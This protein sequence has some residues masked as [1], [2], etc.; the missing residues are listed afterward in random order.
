MLHFNQ[1][2]HVIQAAMAAQGIALGRF[3]LLSAAIAQ[4]RLVTLI[5][6][7][8]TPASSH[9]YW[10][11]RGIYANRPEVDRAVQWI[12]TEAAQ[13]ERMSTSFCKERA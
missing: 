10:L 4:K 7:G 6:Q 8:A 12:R 3:E 9:A 2:D 13:T 5:A 11:I 1:Y